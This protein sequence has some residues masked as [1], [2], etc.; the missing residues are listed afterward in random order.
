MGNNK[1]W[2][3]LLALVFLLAGCGGETAGGTPQNSAPEAGPVSFVAGMGCSDP[4]CTDPSHHHDCPVDCTDYEHHHN[5]ALDCADPS[6]HHEEH[7]D[8]PHHTEAP[9]AA[10]VS[11]IA[12]MGC[13]D[14]TCTDPSHH[15]DCPADC[16][17]Y[18]HHH[19]CPL[20]CTDASHN[21]AAHHEEPHHTAAVEPAPSVAA[22]PE[23]EPAPVPEPAPQPEPPVVQTQTLTAVSYI[24]GMGC[25]DPNCTDPSHYHDC[26]ADCADYEHYHH[27]ALD[28]ADAGH[29]HANHHAEASTAVPVSFVAGMGC[30][31]PNCTDPSH[32][33]DCPADCAN[34]EHH[35]TCALDCA[36][37]SH[38]HAGTTVSTGGGISHGGGHHGRHH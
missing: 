34:Y 18:E 23:P 38:C 5:C 25:S 4:T 1:I 30:S 31:D 13:N 36:E 22:Q 21:H 32:F 2:I 7:H 10:P 3:S 27:C 9:A 12:G 20:D 17:D 28:C 19:H 6:H 37:P 16:A 15:H 29:H 24:S 11:F 8:E 35:H 26:P 33:H 14:P